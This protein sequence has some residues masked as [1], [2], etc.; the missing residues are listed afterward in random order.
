MLCDATSTACCWTASADRAMLRRLLSDMS[1][2]PVE[3]QAAGPG[4]GR[5]RTRDVHGHGIGRAAEELLQKGVAGL[6]GAAQHRLVDGHVLRG[7]A[8]GAANRLAR[9]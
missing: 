7:G 9:G 6:E 1:G 8:G 2:R 4:F 5:A 3:E